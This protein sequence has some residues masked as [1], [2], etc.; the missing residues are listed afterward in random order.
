MRR[1]GSAAMTGKRRYGAMLAV[2][3]GLIGVAMGAAFIFQ[4][5]TKAH[6]L[7]EAMR[8]EGV[9]LGITEELVAKGEVVDSAAEAQ[10]AGDIIRSDRRAIAPTYQELLGGG[11]FDPTNPRHLAYAQALNMENYL[12]LA[13][14]AFGVT[15][16]AIASGAAMIVLGLSL[17]AVGLALLRSRS[18]PG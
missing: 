5:L 11:R 17:G 7:E 6:W 14:L 18:A 4:G 16:M 13:V 1:K 15:T 12:Y 9:T 8:A 2:V 3:G 10:R